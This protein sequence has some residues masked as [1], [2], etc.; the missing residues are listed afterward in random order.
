MTA[1]QTYHFTAH[2]TGGQAPLWNDLAT[3]LAFGGKKLWHAHEYAGSVPWSQAVS[4]DQDWGTSA[5]AGCRGKDSGSPVLASGIPS[6][7]MGGFGDD[8]QAWVRSVL[9][10]VGGDATMRRLDVPA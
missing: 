2:G 8:T 10:P 4:E 7:K 1:A 6:A 3:F 5:G 9:D